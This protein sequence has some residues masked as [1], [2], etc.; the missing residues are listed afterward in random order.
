L[1]DNLQQLCYTLE[2][3]S[4]D[5][6][7]GFLTKFWH[8]HL[9]LQEGNQQQLETYARA[10]IEKLAQ[11]I[12]D[13]EKQFTGIP[14]QTRMLA[15]AF[16]KE[17][18]TFCLSQKSELQLPKQLCL[19]DLY[20]KI[21]KDK[22]YIFKSKGEI[23]EEQHND[24]IMNDI[25]ITKNHQKLA[26][27]VLVPE[28]KDTVLQIEE[29]DMLAPEAI[30]RIGIVQYVDDK[31]HF[32]HRTFAEYYVAD[33]L[34]TQLTKETC[35]LLEILYILFKIL[36]GADYEVIRFFLDGLMVRPEKSKV[37]NQYGEQ[38][39][40]IWRAKRVYI[41]L[42]VKRKKRVIK[43]KFKTLIF[44]AVEEGNAHI[45]DFFFSSLKATG[46]SDTVN[47]LLLYKDTYSGNAWQFAASSGHIKTLETLWSW[48]REVQVNLKD[49]LFLPK[50]WNGQTAWD[51]A[52]E[53]G[54]KEILEKLWG[55]GREVQVNL[56]EDLLLSKGRYYG[57][58]AWDIAAENGNKEIL[59]N[60]WAWGREVQ[61]NL[62]D[63]LLLTKGYYG[64][65]AFYIAAEKGNKEILEKLWG[66]GRK[67]QVNLKDDLLLAKGRN[68]Q[69]AWDIA[70]W[71]GKKEILEKLW[72]WGREVQI[73]LKDDLLLTKGYH[74]QTAFYI[75]AE[76]GNIEI[77]EKLW[78]WGREVQVNLKDDLLLAKVC[79]GKSAWDLLVEKG[80]K[81]ILKKLSVWAREV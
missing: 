62:K 15:E 20:R 48:G 34:V 57:K 73:N 14:L 19:V 67:V 44:R 25:S 4:E 54:N 43:G 50:D 24:I 71:H 55:W 52:A 9:K 23:A 41:L 3:F 72:G 11:S 56:K 49:D 69:T 40:Q 12:S 28:M 26:L 33:F 37:I 6:Q 46:H 17:V 51:V 80:N 39:Y 76:E 5:N 79:Y 13:K 78:G 1:E 77:L 45:I 68:G 30:S 32:I 31:P 27:E 58:T 81:K 38:I 35:F 8:Q 21:I 60:L 10:L 66:W 59:E 64:H 42:K 53:N 47:K 36:L 22:M 70:A 29:S 74:G 2:P 7:I 16:E 63:D 75:A 18:E 65:T 61:V